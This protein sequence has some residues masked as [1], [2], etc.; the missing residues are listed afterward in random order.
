MRSNEALTSPPE[1]QFLRLFLLERL[2]S[3]SPEAVLPP[4]SDPN[5]GKP[6]SPDNYSHYHQILRHIKEVWLPRFDDVAL[7]KC[8][9][10]NAL[11][12]SRRRFTIVGSYKNSEEEASVSAYQLRELMKNASPDTFA[13]TGGEIVYQKSFL[14]GLYHYISL[15]RFTRSAYQDR[16]PHLFGEDN[17][18]IVALQ[19]RALLLLPDEVKDKEIGKELIEKVSEQIESLDN[20]GELAGELMFRHPD[21]FHL[22]IKDPLERPLPVAFLNGITHFVQESEQKKRKEADVLEEQIHIRRKELADVEHDIWLRKQKVPTEDWGF[23]GLKQDIR[24]LQAYL[25]VLIQDQ[26]P[27]AKQANRALGLL[28]RAL[29]LIPS[30]VGFR[31]LENIKDP[32]Y[33]QLVAARIQS[34]LQYRYYSLYNFRPGLRVWVWLSW[35]VLENKLV[36]LKEL[37]PTQFSELKK[38]QFEHEKEIAV[39]L[40]HETSLVAEGRTLADRMVRLIDKGSNWLVLEYI[41]S[42]DLASNMM[43]R[44]IEEGGDQQV[45]KLLFDGR[46]PFPDFDTKEGWPAYRDFIADLAYTLVLL[47]RL[48][49]AHRDIHP[50]NILLRYTSQGD[51]GKYEPVL[52]DLDRLIDL[53]EEE[54]PGFLV[55]DGRSEFDAPER[56]KNSDGTPAA[57][58]ASTVDVYSL[59][60][61][62]VYRFLGRSFSHNELVLRIR[63]KNFSPPLKRLLKR[64]LETDPSQ[65]ITASEFA[66]ELKAIATP[67]RKKKRLL[68]LTLL[69][70]FLLLFGL[71]MNQNR[72]DPENALQRHY[73]VIDQAWVDAQLADKDTLHLAPHPPR[74]YLLMG[75]VCI[76]SGNVLRIDPGVI[77]QADSAASLFIRP[78]AQILAE[79][80]SLSP[81]LFTDRLLPEDQAPNRSGSWGGLIIQGQAP[82]YNPKSGALSTNSSGA[83]MIEFCNFSD[84]HFGEYCAF[85]GDQKEDFSGILRYVVIENGGYIAMQDYEINALTLAGVGDRTQ[86]SHIQIRNTLDDGLEIFGGSVEVDHLLVLNPRDDGIDI[87]MGYSG[88]VSDVVVLLC[89]SASLFPNYEVENG[90]NILE[91]DLMPMEMEQFPR[92]E[93]IYGANVSNVDTILSP[94]IGFQAMF[95]DEAWLFDSI[96]HCISHLG[97]GK[98]A[99]CPGPLVP[100]EELTLPFAPKPFQLPEQVVKDYL[101]QDWVFIQHPDTMKR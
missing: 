91:I 101:S 81:I 78:Q 50:G 37:V 90:K 58:G 59:A 21:I 82:V 99:S 16:Y 74:P 73:S 10:Y 53:D 71:W 44:P 67:V 43:P 94:R 60:A 48:H 54:I 25:S 29:E 68:L 46:N 83:A 19:Q 57:L 61:I 55:V 52:C 51:S 26:I 24:P 35:D 84:H 75:R 64:S 13:D 100:D 63:K 45:E 33:E 76:D 7:E 39:R 89:D 36:I 62:L 15:G 32:E 1:R 41:E 20:S 93:R 69:I 96:P 98:A 66:E 79:G 40:G 6:L 70:P 22:F 80:T 56:T 92:F 77:I 47:D 27:N 97:Y 12:P 88:E 34:G 28:H 49:L 4:Q 31:F 3:A 72:N 65:R 30:L 23:L 86:I 17:S 2:R 14:E 5:T 85:G 8:E 9:N 18:Q 87:S 95:C 38:C 42:G 11:S